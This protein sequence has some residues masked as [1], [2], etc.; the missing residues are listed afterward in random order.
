MQIVEKN[1]NA[2]LNVLV[3]DGVAC[4]VTFR[5]PLENISVWMEI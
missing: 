3:I 1:W 2:P 5:I 4:N